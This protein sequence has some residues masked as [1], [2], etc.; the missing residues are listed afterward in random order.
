M[1]NISQIVELKIELRQFADLSVGF[2]PT[3]GALHQG[4]IS[5]IERAKKE[6]DIVVVSVFL[7]PTQFD[8]KNDL[9]NYP[10]SLKDDI[11]I[12]EKLNVDYLFTPS[13]GEMYPDDFTYKIEETSF[14]KKLCG[15]SRKGHF[16]GMLTV[17]M[18][19]LNIIKPVRAYF[20][21]K[22]R[23]QLL[24]IRGMVD[25]F[26]MDIKIVAS[27]TVRESNGLAMSSRN[28]RLSSDDKKNAD[29][30]PVLLKSKKSD[31][32]IIDELNKS[33]FRTDY[34]E[35]LDGIRYGA[36]FLS[37]IRLIDN[38]EI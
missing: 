24:L 26:F 19:L 34:V 16:S 11:V 38:V 22:D 10:S 23:Q 32:E 21:E 4:H 6:N 2:V 3:M 1:K 20:G 18:K 35:T 12:L 13:Y 30:F 28:R 14:S 25:A 15:K 36:V 31:S 29:L 33:G 7:N 8:N 27:P 17:V 9:T 37:N 5:L